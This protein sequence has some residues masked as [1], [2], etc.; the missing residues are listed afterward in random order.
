MEDPLQN[1]LVD[2]ERV[3]PL[4]KPAVNLRELVESVLSTDPNRVPSQA[5]ATKELKQLAAQNGFYV[6]ASEVRLATEAIAAR[7]DRAPSLNPELGYTFA[8]DLILRH[9]LK[10]IEGLRDNPSRLGPNVFGSYCTDMLENMLRANQLTHAVESV[11]LIS[12]RLLSQSIEFAP[13]RYAYLEL[14]DSALKKSRELIVHQWQQSLTLKRRTPR[15]RNAEEGSA[16]DREHKAQAQEE[17]AVVY[18]SKLAEGFEKVKLAMTAEAKTAVKGTEIDQLLELVTPLDSSG[19][20][21]FGAWVMQRAGAMLLPSDP[22]RA[23][24]LLANS[25]RMFE[26]QADAECRAGLLRLSASR[27]SIAL[28]LFTKLGEVESAGT[29][30]TKLQP[31]HAN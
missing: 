15:I 31:R 14:A 10:E 11:V 17:R 9:L 4:A 24:A 21:G 27:Y 13:L 26:S 2:T 20:L 19:F 12:E 5:D 3:T 6:M 1:E 7:K 25:A 8:A 16:Q 30:R 23:R 28:E 29:V 22:I 18:L